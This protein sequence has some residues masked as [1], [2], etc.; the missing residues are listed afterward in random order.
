MPIQIVILQHS[1]LFSKTKKVKTGLT[2]TSVNRYLEVHVLLRFSSDIE[3]KCIIQPGFWQQKPKLKNN[4]LKFRI[5]ISSTYRYGLPQL[6]HAQ[7]K[8]GWKLSSAH[9][10]I[11]RRRGKANTRLSSLPAGQ[12]PATVKEKVKSNHLSSKKVKLGSIQVIKLGNDMVKLISSA[13][14]LNKALV[15]LKFGL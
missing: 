12:N 6:K 11:L 13:L 8:I 5:N 3:Q 2:L 14:C 4:E 1:D 15:A 9:E 7:S 10:S